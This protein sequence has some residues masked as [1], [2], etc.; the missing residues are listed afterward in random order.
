MPDLRLIQVADRIDCA[1]S[2]AKLSAVAEH[3]F[4]FIARPDDKPILARREIVEHNHACTSHDV[5]P[6]DIVHFSVMQKVAVHHRADIDT[7]TPDSELIDD[8]FRVR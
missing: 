7:L 1:G 2:V 5:P 8:K 4:S 6:P 3:D